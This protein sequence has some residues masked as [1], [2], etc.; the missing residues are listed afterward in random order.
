MP[1]GTINLQ[2]WNGGNNCLQP[3]MNVS[4]YSVDVQH[5]TTVN[6][7]VWNQFL[8]WAVKDNATYP[9]YQLNYV[10]PEWQGPLE[11][12][13]FIKSS[14]CYDFNWRGFQALYDLGAVMNS[15]AQFKHDYISYYTSVP[16][17]PVDY[18]DPAWRE[19][20]NAYY[21]AWDF[22]RHDLIEDLLIWLETIL[23]SDKFMFANGQYWYLKELHH[24]WFKNVYDW[25]CMPGVNCSSWKPLSSVHSVHPSLLS[26]GRRK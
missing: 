25:Q 17:V 7:T 2:W 10:I 19:R 6:G 23:L 11:T 26:A 15:T 13:F 20:I 3:G 18:N 14:T 24:P 4:Y 8:Q 5:A 9:E 12:K 1:N 21:V 16:P 22:H